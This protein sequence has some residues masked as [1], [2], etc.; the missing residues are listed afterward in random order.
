MI[1][2]ELKQV[3]VEALKL[4]ELPGNVRQLESLI[5]Q[6]L[7]NKETDAPLGLSDLPMEILCQLSADKERSTQTS[8][9]APQS[10]SSAP[11]LPKF[12]R[13]PQV[14]RFRRPRAAFTPN[15]FLDAPLW[16]P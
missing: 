11:T 7:V 1:K 9:T 16:L 3:I 10:D 12:A 14:C 2:N 13:P 4:A 15:S 5:C 8:E 6:A